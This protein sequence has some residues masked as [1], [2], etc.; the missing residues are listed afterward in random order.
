MYE[1]LLLGGILLVLLSCPLVETGKDLT[2]KN[3]ST[4]FGYGD[5]TT[6]AGTVTGEGNSGGATGSSAVDYSKYMLPI[7]NTMKSTR[8]RQMCEAVFSGNVDKCELQ[9]EYAEKEACESMIAAVMKKP[10]MCDS[11][12]PFVTGIDHNGKVVNLTIS[13]D[14]YG[15]YAV[16]TLDSSY[17]EKS[18]S[19]ENCQANIKMEKGEITLEQCNGGYTCLMDYAEITKDKRACE[20]FRAASGGGDADSKAMCLAM[21]TGD[22]SHC[23]SITSIDWKYRCIG[24]ARWNKAMESGMMFQVS[25]CKGNSD[26]EMKVLFSM[27]KWAA[28]N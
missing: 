25:E 4:L 19:P 8:W 12:N 3:Q 22:E 5:D 26:C 10:A 9:R 2:E 23:N 14:C 16:A 7:C 15:H 28:R 11:V 13:T 20:Q 17:C 24:L 27:E 18:K 6:G 21:V 1:K